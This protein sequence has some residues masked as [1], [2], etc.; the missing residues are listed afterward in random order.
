MIKN[1]CSLF[2]IFF[3]LFRFCYSLLIFKKRYFQTMKGAITKD[4]DEYISA[5]PKEVQKK[6]EQV[7]STIQKAAPKAEEAIKYAIPTFVL[8]KTNLAHFAAFTNHIGFYPTP[9]G[10]EAFEKE[11]SKY[12]TGK[13]SMQIPFDQPLPLA[14]IEKIVK[15]NIKR[16]AE[17]AILKK[18]K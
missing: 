10:I 2:T 9:T 4:I 5:F 8:D 12:K 3:S 15:Y 7:R 13:G 11:L 17:K 18:K 6:L 1:G 16:N 14:L